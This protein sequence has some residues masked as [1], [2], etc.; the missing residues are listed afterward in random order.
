[1]HKLDGLR[2]RVLPARQD[3]RQE[4]IRQG[5]GE[6]RQ[7]RRGLRASSRPRGLLGSAALQ[8]AGRL[9]QAPLQGVEGLEFE[10]RVDRVLDEGADV[11]Q[12]AVQEEIPGGA[13][14]R[15]RRPAVP[16]GRQGRGREAPAQAAEG[17]HP[18]QAQHKVPEGP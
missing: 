11:R 17:L 3:E 13:L 4:P 10:V 1:M 18:P 15:G 5:L 12:E 8:D 9:V 6:G 2:Q 16:E 7:S 14:G